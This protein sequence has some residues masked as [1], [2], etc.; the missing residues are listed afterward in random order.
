MILNLIKKILNHFI[1]HLY[2]KT[3]A[4]LFYKSVVNKKSLHI[5]SSEN[6][7]NEYSNTA[8]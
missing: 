2:R 1:M 7:Y 4:L 3:V 6:E 5:F 8:I